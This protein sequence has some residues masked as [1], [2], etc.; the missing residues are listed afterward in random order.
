MDE[1][2][3]FNATVL[4]QVFH[5]VLLLILLRIFAYKPLLRVMDER[6]RLVEESLARVER[7]RREAAARKDE[8]AQE[9]QHARE[10]AEEIVHRATVQGEERASEIVE[11]ARAEV[12]RMHDEARE[13]IRREQE[14]AAAV[15][16]EE[17]ASLALMAAGKIVQRELQPEDHREVIERVLARAER[18]I[19]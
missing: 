1:F 13:V 2:P 4:A 5:F 9:L 19:C 15:L 7:D 14:Q 6:R 12:Q 8:A 10:E 16:C 17:V 18:L 11:R 3:I